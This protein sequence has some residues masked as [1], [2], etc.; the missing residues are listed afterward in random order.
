MGW[1]KDGR[2]DRPRIRIERREYEKWRE[3]RYEEE[4]EKW[5]SESP[6]VEK[7][8]F[9]LYD[10]LYGNIWT[11]QCSIDIVWILSNLSLYSFCSWAMI[12]TEERITV[13]VQSVFEL[14]YVG[15]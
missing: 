5:P 9:Y 2:N 1:R 10:V 14:G 7:T 15:I 13:T 4:R 6:S 12:D 11:L 8:L 3:L